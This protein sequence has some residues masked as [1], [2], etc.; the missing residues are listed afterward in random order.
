[1]IVD[2]ETIGNFKVSSKF[3]YYIHGRAQ[4]FIVF[5]LNYVVFFAIVKTL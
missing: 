5:V 4:I 1:M 3:T 2:S